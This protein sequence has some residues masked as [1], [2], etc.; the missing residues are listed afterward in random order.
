M[1]KFLGFNS[2]LSEAEIVFLGLPF[3]GTVTFRPGSRF[4]PHAVRAMSEGIETYSPYQ[5]KDLENKLIGDYGDLLLPFG[6]TAK[7]MQLIEAK[8]E[9]L[10][11]DGK[12]I[13]SCGGE[14]LVSYPIIKAYARKYPEISVI[15]IDA[16]TDLREH[17]LGEKLSHAS[18]I[19][20]VCNHINPQNIYQ[21][22]IRSGQKV[23]FEWA[24]KNTNFYPFSL[25][26]ITE[27][28]KNN[29]IYLTLDLDVLD[30]AYL[31]G[32]GTPEPGGLSFNELLEGLLKLQGS[33]IVGADIVELSPDYDHSGASTMV[34]VKLIRELALLFG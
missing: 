12:K 22:G 23:E 5:K 11:E 16:H 33:N 30:P 26:K 3:D 25:E 2:E 24:E 10:L 21:Y 20:L 1:D 13:L 29:P 4:A 32:T 17:Y 8:A 19:K 9:E 34:A 7:T 28:P 18:V 14:H 31:P 27:L 6:N 15:H